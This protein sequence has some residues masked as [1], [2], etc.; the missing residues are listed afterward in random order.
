MDIIT[1]VDHDIIKTL[2]NRT[3]GVTYEKFLDGSYQIYA[4]DGFHFVE[5]VTHTHYG[6]YSY[7]EM[8]EFAKDLTVTQCMNLDAE[9]YCEGDDLDPI[10]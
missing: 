10:N 5:T 2:R 7:K 3:D 9:G 6:G 1:G 4:P 8:K